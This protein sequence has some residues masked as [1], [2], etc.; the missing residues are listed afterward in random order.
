MSAGRLMSYRRIQ[1]YSQR[2]NDEKEK[3]SQ[4]YRDTKSGETHNQFHWMGGDER[5][6]F[7]STS[8]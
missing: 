1:F 5:K 7:Q 8:K 2:K 3:E 6:R 4:L